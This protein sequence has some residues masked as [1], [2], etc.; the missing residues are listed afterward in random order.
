[1]EKLKARTEQLEKMLSMKEESFAE[2]REE[3]KTA[4]T[5]MQSDNTLL[6]AE[7]RELESKLTS[8]Q[9]MVNEQGDLEDRLMKLETVVS[10]E[11]SATGGNGFVSDETEMGKE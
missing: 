2:E 5:Q 11:P 6:F 8:L 7:K 4:Q 9:Q 10:R 3:F 1:M